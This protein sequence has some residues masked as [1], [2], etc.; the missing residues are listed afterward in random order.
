MKRFNMLLSILLIIAAMAILP[1]CGGSSLGGGSSSRDTDGGSGSGGDG[2]GPVKL[3]FT[4]D[5]MLSRNVAELVYE[6]GGGDYSWPFLKI[7]DFLN[8]AD[9]TI[10]NLEGPISD[11]GSEYL[12]SAPWFRAE[13]EAVNGLNY[14]GIDIVSLA[15]NHIFDY[16]REAMEDCFGQLERAGIRYMGA[17]MTREEA[18]APVIVN[19]NGLK[20]AFLAFTNHGD[21]SWQ[22]EVDYY[23]TLEE[24]LAQVPSIG[25]LFLQAQ[26]LTHLMTMPIPVTEESSGVAWLYIKQL[27]RAIYKAREEADIV[28]VSL[29]FGEEYAEDISTAQDRYAHLAIDRGAD[30][31]VGHHP[32]VTQ[33]IMVYMG[34]VI[35]YSLGNFVF[36]QRES[37][38]AG[39]TMGLV[40]EVN[41]EDKKI[42]N[43]EGHYTQIIEEEWQTQLTP[44]EYGDLD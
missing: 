11:K 40:L 34:K 39:T 12:K 7:A 17:G 28:I 32:H 30:M 21:A 8:D 31:V 37:Y 13:P 33:P 38:E 36:D 10:S 42:Q 19:I 41:I 22:A 23:T 35:A 1:G 24:L 18:Y 6:K 4:G 9:L 20:I 43:V 14:A 5:V 15:N 2:T 3:L 27:E 29:H 16:G 25:D 44:F 26:V